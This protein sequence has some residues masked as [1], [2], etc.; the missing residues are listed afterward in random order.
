MHRK[1]S[2]WSAR[3]DDVAIAMLSVMF[4]AFV[5]QIT[6]RYVFD[7]PL[8]WTLELCLTMWLWTVLW[9][10]AFCLTNQEHVRFDMIYMASTERVRRWLAGIAA[11]A[12]VLTMVASAAGTYDFVSF[13]TIKK[14]GTLRI[15]L[16]Y[17][18]S[19]YLLF[20]LAVVVRYGHRMLHIVRGTHMDQLDA[21]PAQGD[22]R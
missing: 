2:W 7:A 1:Q 9:G 18:F 16:A 19:I 20:M 17:V 8:G 4:L 3:A 11:I 22:Q 14:S 21:F 13:L 6:S 12:V 10:S 15:P 5:L